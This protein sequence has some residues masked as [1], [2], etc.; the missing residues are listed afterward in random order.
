M[1]NGKWSKNNRD[2]SE[3]IRVVHFF[4][5]IFQPLLFFVMRLVNLVLK[6]V[7]WQ[8]NHIKMFYASIYT[9]DHIWTTDKKVKTWLIIA[10]VK[11]RTE[12]TS[13]LN[14]A[15][16][17]CGLA[18]MPDIT[19]FCWTRQAKFAV[20]LTYLLVILVP[21]LKAENE[22]NIREFWLRTMLQVWKKW[23]D[24][25]RSSKQKRLRTL[26]AF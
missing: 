20:E 22:I 12:N 18:Q 14:G 1:K 26:Y 25:R 15:H 5:D 23:R 8:I 6:L 13:G 16:D 17:L 3:I 7:S 19:R 9:E 21:I 10:V 11:L 2:V 4:A 24:F